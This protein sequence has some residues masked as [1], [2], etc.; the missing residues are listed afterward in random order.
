MA[1]KILVVDDEADLLAMMVLRLRSSGYVPLTASSGEEALDL[2]DK[3]KPDLILLDLLLPNIQGPQIC[4][5][6]KSDPEFK[7]IPIIVFTA[8]ITH[9]NGRPRRWELTTTC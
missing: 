6:L 3:H 4:K 7:D 9:I 8:S 5:K 1:K 2:L